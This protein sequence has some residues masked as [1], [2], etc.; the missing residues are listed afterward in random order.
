MAEKKRVSDYGEVFT[1]ERE[2]TAMLNL[3]KQET[4]RWTKLI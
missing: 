2:V 3:V 4:E 1:S